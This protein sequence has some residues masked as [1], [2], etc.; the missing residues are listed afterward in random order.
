[1]GGVQYRE[2]YLEYR[3]GVQ[4]RGGYH[5]YRGG[6]LEYRGGYSVL[7][8]YHEYRGGKIFCEHPHGT[9]H[10]LYRVITRNHRKHFH[11]KTRVACAAAL[12]YTR[13]CINTLTVR[14]K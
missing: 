5:E 9:A 14:L 12:V 3:G 13:T 6:Y 8:G 7:W 2:G 10:T 4:Y 11:L 1:M